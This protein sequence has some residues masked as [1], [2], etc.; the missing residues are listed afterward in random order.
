MKILLGS[1]L[2]SLA[3]ML[4]PSNAASLGAIV[5]DSSSTRE[6]PIFRR[7]VWEA[8]SGIIPSGAK[9]FMEKNSQYINEPV[10]FMTLGAVDLG[11]PKKK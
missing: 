8:L 9:T 7:G 6:H 10:K 4:P 2:V 3:L 11:A 1:L 5:D